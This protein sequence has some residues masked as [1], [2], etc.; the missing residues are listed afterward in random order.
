MHWTAWLV[1]G[2]LVAWLVVDN[3]ADPFNDFEE[4]PFDEALARMRTGDII[5]TTR[6]TPSGLVQKYALGAR[7]THV[8]M[9]V[10]DPASDAIFLY[11]GCKWPRNKVDVIPLT[12]DYLFA[13]TYAVW[14]P[15]EKP[16]DART[17]AR[18]LEHVRAHDGAPYEIWYTHP[19]LPRLFPWLDALVPTAF[20]E[21]RAEPHGTQCAQAVFLALADVGLINRSGYTDDGARVL[22]ADFDYPNAFTALPWTHAPIWSQDRPRRLVR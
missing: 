4:I 19:V 20:R 1:L 10:R 5:L 17:E 2:L 13:A 3:V 18:L 12:R 6:P 22:P 9:V 15:L 8:A 14:W 7:A 11:E 16:L 21:H